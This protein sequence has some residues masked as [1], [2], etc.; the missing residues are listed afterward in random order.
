MSLPVV[1][2]WT[3]HPEIISLGPLSIR[4]YGILF[5][6]GFGLGFVVTQRIF[7]LE[8]VPDSWLDPLL[9][10]MVLGGLI[11]AR[12]GHV[13]FY[14]W[15]EFQH[16]LWE[17]PM[18]WRGGLASHGGAIGTLLAFGL[19]SWK[20][21]K[22]SM[23]WVMD[24]T[25]PAGAIGAMFIRLGNF[26]NHEIVGIQT[27][28][29]WAVSFQHNVH[30]FVHVP[31]HPAQLYE[32][33]AYLFIFVILWIVYRRWQGSSYPGLLSG[34]YL[35]L[36]FSAR[37]GLEFLKENQVAFEEG[38]RLNMGQWLSLPLI[39]LGCCFI[40]YALFKRGLGD[41]KVNN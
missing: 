41:K 32:A 26:F 6:T 19:F 21:S 27:N 40:S 13:F 36:V 5:A 4:W 18:I 37:F 39:I 3:V 29:P 24:R 28:V 22:K 17:I 1:I 2:E 10:Y 30:E 7:R 34:L 11:G 8:K 23:F 9:L 33:I 31:R 38:M 25:A 20:I 35:V 12:L 14:D 15:A 16:K